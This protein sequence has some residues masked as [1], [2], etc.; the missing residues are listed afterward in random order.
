[1]TSALQPR[2]EIHRTTSQKKWS[3]L[4]L[5]QRQREIAT[6]IRNEGTLGTLLFSEVSPV[7]TYGRRTGSADVYLSLEQAEKSGVDLL[8]VDRGGMATYHGPGQWVVFPVDTLSRLVGD[9]RGVRKTV[10]ALLESAREAARSLL[11]P[12][13]AAQIQIKDGC[14][15]GVWSG[16]QKICSVGIHIEDGVLLHGLALNVFPTAQSFVGLRPCGLDS[17]MGYLFSEP[18][19]DHFLAARN[20][21]ELQI[22]KRFWRNPK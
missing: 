17:K 5:D 11:P 13:S 10:E 16:D 4:L 2:I 3:Y 18:S 7:I 21:L 22:L 12:E 9:S 19:E 1:M 15:T 8:P 6:Q 14:E 20:Q